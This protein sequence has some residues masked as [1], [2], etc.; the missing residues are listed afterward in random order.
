LG[1]AFKPLALPSTQ[2][3]LSWVQE[4]QHNVIALQNKLNQDQD[5]VHAGLIEVM[6]TKMVDYSSFMKVKKSLSIFIQFMGED[7]LSHLFQVI[8]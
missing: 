4:R 1:R 2:V 5:A 7:I 6:Q 3:T 8:G